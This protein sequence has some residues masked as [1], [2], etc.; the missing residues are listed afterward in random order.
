MMASVDNKHFFAS[1]VLREQMRQIM[2][3]QDDPSRRVRS[4]N[5]LNRCGEAR[6]MRAQCYNP[7]SPRQLHFRMAFQSQRLFFFFPLVILVGMISP[8]AAQEWGAPARELAEKIA[9]RAQSRSGLSLTVKNISS[10]P[11]ARVADLQRALESELQRR[12][13]RLVAS[14]QAM[15]QARVTLSKNT[16]GYLLVGEVGRDE[17]WDV[18]MVQTTLSATAEQSSAA[19]VLRRMLLWSQPDPILD[20]VREDGGLIVLGRDSL[21][22]YRAQDKK[23]QLAATAPLMHSRPWPR[24]LR[25][26][27]VVQADGALRAYLPGVQCSGTTQP[28]LSLAC[29]ESHDPWPLSSEVSA[30][31]SERRN[32]FTGTVTLGRT[33]QA[34]DLNAF[35][36]VARF[37]EGDR[38]FWI[39]AFSDGAMRLIN[40]QGQ[41]VS[42]FNG[43]GSDVTAI[44]NDCGTGWQ[45][46]A[47]S[48][49]DNTLPDSLTAYEI[50]NRDAVE[51]ASPMQFGGPII[52]L[53]SASDGR[54][55]TLIAHNLRTGEYEAFSVSAVC[56]R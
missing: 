12:G 16:A 55:A 35:Y 49:A 29:N 53:W 10:L 32:Y 31:F 52:A 3:Q 19:L 41:T 43:W 48:A 50:V 22:V 5:R 33:S 1:D 7:A 42:T 46:M 11:P 36:S 9:T 47:S 37:A 30:F 51:A 14:E 13:V 15:E 40:D 54:A 2:Q 4:L 23:W 39:V 38:G 17:S 18:V 34:A 25:G 45:V 24:D 6:A 26:R 20:V 56:S 21:S 44:A 28:Q 8:V 27:L